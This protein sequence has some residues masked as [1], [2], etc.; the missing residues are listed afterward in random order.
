MYTVSDIVADI[1]RGC[2]ANNLNED[3]FRYRI[4]FFVNETEKGSKHYVDAP[5]GGLRKALEDIIRDHLSLTNNIVIAETTVLKDGKSVC[6]Q[7]RSY[8][9]S[10]MGYFERISGEGREGSSKGRV[11]Y[12]R[13]V[14][15]NMNR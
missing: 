9:F 15:N 12:G 13:Y 4:I 5:Y 6:L 8:P 7:S 11:L 1:G 10:L 3:M 2:I 14:A